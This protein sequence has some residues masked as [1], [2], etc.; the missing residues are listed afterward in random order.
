MSAFDGQST[1]ADHRTFLK[2]AWSKGKSGNPGGRPKGLTS[3]KRRFREAFSEAPPKDAVSLVDVVL[4][5]ARGKIVKMEKV[6]DGDGIHF[7]WCYVES[8]NQMAAIKFAAEYGFGPPPKTLDDESIDRL[9]LQRVKG[10]VEGARAAHAQASEP[11]RD[12]IDVAATGE[13]V[14]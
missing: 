3:L 4:E 14:K 8:K 5:M 7:E 13:P 6:V 10:L 9:V 11:A 12:A 1:G 2:P